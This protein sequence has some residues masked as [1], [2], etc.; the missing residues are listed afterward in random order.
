MRPP[1]KG[2]LLYR[3][4]L[5]G[6]AS[7]GLIG[8]IDLQILAFL[9]LICGPA[10]ANTSVT[11]SHTFTQNVVYTSGTPQWDDWDPF[12]TNAPSSGI[13]SITIRG[14]R[15]TVGRTCSVPALAQQIMNNFRTHQNV[16][17]DPAGNM[18]VACDGFNW[19]T[20]ACAVAG[21]Q[22]TEINAGSATGVCL[23]TT[24]NYTV[25]PRIRATSW[26][27][28]NGNTIT[29]TTQSMTVSYAI[30]TSTELT[31]AKSV[32]VFDPISAG[33]YA[34]PGNDFISSMLVTNIGNGAADVD[35][36]VIIDAVPPE[37]TFYN[38]DMD[39]SGPA[40]GAIYFTQAGVTN[41][42]FNPLTDAA[43]SNDATRP[44]DMEACNYAPTA[45]Y[46]ANVTYVCFNPK[47][48]MAAGDPDPSFT[49]QFRS[50]LK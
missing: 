21:V 18:V 28:I 27:G 50:Q 35:S 33:L 37:M 1:F 2:V 32:A 12:R 38:G 16:G 22:G 6:L 31:A 36:I 24:T 10:A 15:D 7:K 8:F 30:N 9:L 17:T 11:Y 23:G 41:L 44:E 48:A 49:L 25:R 47:G 42:T 5:S 40:T 39:D 43:Y 45:G 19:N 34:L 4:A 3:K 20:G 13:Q 14:S 26:G 46:D 29:A